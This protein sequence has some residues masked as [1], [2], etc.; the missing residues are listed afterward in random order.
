MN[1]PLAPY[2][3]ISSGLNLFF[4]LIIGIA[5]GFILERGGL[6]NAKKLIGQFTLTDLTVFKVMFTAIVTVMIGLFFLSAFGLANLELIS[7][8]DTYWIP[9][10]LGGLI[11][12]VGFAVAGYCPGT[13]IVGMATGKLDALASFLGLIFGSLVF[14]A[15][16]DWIE[17]FYWSTHLKNDH[18]SQVFA[19]EFGT[20]VFIVI[21]IAILGFITAE[22][23]ESKSRGS[24]QK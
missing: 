7:N 23:I 22:I 19:I 8:S 12:G 14:V 11:L 2:E 6:G 13:T 21:C 18:F 3:V 16:F 9:Q 17:D 24:T 10:I 5:F 20:S 1:M 15:I 4:A